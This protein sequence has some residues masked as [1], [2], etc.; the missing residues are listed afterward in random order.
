ML[1]DSDV[2]LITVTQDCM[3]KARAAGKLRVSF[4]KEHLGDD[5]RHMV[6]VYTPQCCF[7]LDRA[8]YLKYFN[9]IYRIN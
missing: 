3:L 6:E 2:H 7:R 1:S 8:A 4:S 9:S 5:G